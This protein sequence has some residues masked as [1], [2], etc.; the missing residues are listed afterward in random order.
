MEKK[1]FDIKTCRGMEK[2]VEISSCVDGE[3]RLYLLESAKYG[4][5][6]PCIIIRE[7]KDLSYYV[8][9]YDWFDSLFDWLQEN[10]I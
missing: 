3:T 4:E 9:E 2:F 6:V 8:E 10:Q 5:N 7:R 1:I